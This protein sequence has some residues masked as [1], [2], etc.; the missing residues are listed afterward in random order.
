VIGRLTICDLMIVKRK[1]YA[2][3]QNLVYNRVS[4]WISPLIPRMFGVPQCCR[5]SATRL[6]PLG[7]PGTPSSKAGMSFRIKCA[8]TAQIASGM[9]R[10]QGHWAAAP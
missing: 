4:E 2:H 1:K 9:L 6:K 5:T 8:P 7:R 3:H 10:L